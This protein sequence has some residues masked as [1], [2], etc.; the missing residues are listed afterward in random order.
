MTQLDCITVRRHI[1][2]GMDITRDSQRCKAIRAHIQTC[3]ECKRYI[4][5][6][7]HVIDCYRSYPFEIPNDTDS[8][9]EQAIERIHKKEE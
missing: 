8:L 7:E 6:L 5:S 9:I 4:E 2:E 3:S 1:G